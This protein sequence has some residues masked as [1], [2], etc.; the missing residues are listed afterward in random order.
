MGDR[1]VLQVEGIVKEYPGVRAVDGAVVEVRSGEIHALV[2]ENGAGKSTLIKVISGVVRPDAGRLLLHG[3][4]V[5]FRSVQEARRAGI[6]T[7]QQELTLVP[8][9]SAAENI[10]LGQPYPKRTLGLVDWPALKRAAQEALRMLGLDLSPDLPVRALS[11][12]LQTMVAIAGALS[13]QASLLI[14]DEP[15]ASL[16]DE[17]AGHLFSVLRSLKERGMAVLYV[18]HRLE[19]IFQIADRI[20]VMRD[21]RTV[22]TLEA[23]A[24]DAEALIRLMTGRSL[25]EEPQV[26]QGLG[27]P[28]LEVEGLAASTLKGVSFVLHRGEILGIGGLA[29]SGRSQLLRCLY[30]A[31][32][33]IS[34]RMRLEGSPV[35]PRSPAEALSLGIAM[36]PE[37]RR[38]QGL[39]LSLAL[40]QN[41]TLAHLR[42]YSLL[43]TFLQRSRE[44]DVAGNMV[45]RL[46]I[47]ARSLTQRVSQLSG[48]TQQ[49]VVFAR[50]LAG[51]VRVLLL[52]EPTRGIDVAT[53]FEIHQII[54]DL[55]AKGSGILLVTSELP[56]LMQLSHRILVLREGRQVGVFPA[57]GLSQQELLAHFYGRVLA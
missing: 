2:G 41:V 31:E 7:L 50:Y 6:S 30:G 49:K 28:L 14:L 19:E 46:G 8:T 36:V 48:G 38:S 22:A 37:E 57:S 1:V 21:G 53:K 25:G 45:R 15:T 51:P 47:K 34:G 3:Q 54:R 52:D 24:T 20:T 32:P 35:T 56:E 10:F 5:A 4:Q 9:L 27:E 43:G 18:S 17:E 23:E 40:F 16:T 42:S 39:V 26:P 29:G 33:M 44:L 11:P 55:A 13:R 12:A